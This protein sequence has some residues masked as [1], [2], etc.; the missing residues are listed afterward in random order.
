M[1]DRAGDPDTS[2]IPLHWQRTDQGGAQSTSV[3]PSA[4]TLS[5]PANT[6]LEGWQ[7]LGPI[8]LYTLHPASLNLHVPPSNQVAELST[9]SQP[10]YV[11]SSK[12]K[13]YPPDFQ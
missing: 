1:Q 10:Y 13:I 8:Y 11:F 2:H 5:P 7:V 12:D 3:P 9:C 6:T 4:P